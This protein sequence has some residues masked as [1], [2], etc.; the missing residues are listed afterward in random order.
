MCWARRASRRYVMVVVGFASQFLPWVLV[1]R[2]TFIYHYFASVPFIIL[3]STLLLEA[4]RR[5]SEQAFHITAGALLGASLVLFAGFY[6]L[7]SGLPCPRAYAKYLRW[8]KWY[9]F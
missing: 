3:A 6:P 2:S 7:E 4:I 9:N 8:F 1:P 5:K